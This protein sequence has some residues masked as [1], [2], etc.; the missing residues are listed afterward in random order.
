MLEARKKIGVGII[1]FLLVALVLA[2]IRFIHHRMRY[3]VS[4]AVFV[5]TDRLVNLSFEDVSGRLLKVLKDEGQLVKAGEP[6]ALLDPA[7]YQDEVKRLSA[8]LAAMEQKKAA[9]EILRNRVSREVQ[10]Q[11]ALAQDELKRLEAKEKALDAEIAAL[12]VDIEQLQRDVTRLR[13]LYAKHLIARHKLEETE[14]AWRKAREKKKALEA[15][16]EAVHIG[17]DQAHKKLLL[18]RNQR[19]QVKQIDRELAAL[20]EKIKGVQ[21]ALARTKLL[22]KHCVL[23]SPLNG[24]VAKR[25]HVAGDVVGPGEPVLALVDPHDLYIL[26]LLEETKLHGVKPG[27]PA[28]VRIDAYPK[29]HFEGVV[30]E[31]LPA[32]AAKF[33]LVPRDI[34]A[35]EFTKV[36]QRV[37]VKIRITKG[38]VDLLRVGLGGEV[39]IK[40]H[41]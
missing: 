38:P 17:L 39:E 41:E 33:A 5:E 19:K 29:A 37:P 26:V 9:T 16:K 35:G 12:S 7:P 36:A 32:T 22:L 20:A 40:R 3:A 13:R 24:V 34:S 27:C 1:V 21:A 28:R 6:A 25:F 4:N 15:E 2:L 10:L 8:E 18:A 14:T 11:E 31:V 30:S 23:K